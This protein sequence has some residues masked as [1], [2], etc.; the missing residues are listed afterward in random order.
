MDQV[1]RAAFY[2]AFSLLLAVWGHSAAAAT[3]H[4]LAV[5]PNG[6]LAGWGA[7][8]FGQV[9]SGLATMVATPLRLAAP[10]VKLVTVVAGSRHSL[11]LD[12]AGKVWAWGDNSS[13]QLGLGHTR[14]VSSPTLV[15]K[16]PAKARSLA[17]GAQHS[18]ALLAD[19]TVWVWGANNRGQLG[20]GATDAFA[21]VPQPTQVPALSGATDLAA[22]DDFVM[23]LM[24]SARKTGK[25]GKAEPGLW[26]WG[27]GQPVPHPVAGVA[28]AESIRAAGDLAMARNAS[29]RYWQWK[30]GPLDHASLT[31]P[32]ASNQ[33]AYEHLGTMTHTAL[34]ALTTVAVAVKPAT[35]TALAAAPA[36]PTPTPVVAPTPPAPL[37]PIAPVAPVAPVAVASVAAPVP[38]P[39]IPATPVVPAVA[40]KVS[41]SGTVRLSNS[42]L[43]GVQVA[44]EGAQCSATDSQGRYVCNTTTGWSGKVRVLRNNY[45]FSPSSLSFQN[46][47]VDA[48]QQDFAATYDPR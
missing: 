7:N 44:A 23:V 22:G 16:L 31:T 18:A 17:A 41:V 13:G 1:T 25:A 4:G 46:L 38:A 29:N 28:H 33:Q 42:P 27:S 36:A 45:R 40:V 12:E 32:T 10:G 5:L 2:A 15:A 48:G 37:V 9:Q 19:G 8:E 14:P 47:N 34:A 3:G 21:V 6:A 30:V 20:S 35:A 11:A 43:E 39:P 26:L 24:G